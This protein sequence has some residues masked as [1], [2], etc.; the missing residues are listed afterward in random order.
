MIHVSALVETRGLSASW[1]AEFSIRNVIYRFA[2]GSLFHNLRFNLKKIHVLFI[3]IW[4][5]KML[6]SSYLREDS[7]FFLPVELQKKEEEKIEK[8]TREPNNL[9]GPSMD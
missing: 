9:L 8:I 1:L 7:P 3:H 4:R 2:F 5:N 6:K